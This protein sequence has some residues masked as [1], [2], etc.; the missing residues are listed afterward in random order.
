MFVLIVVR[1][2][3]VPVARHRDGAG[4]RHV[5]PLSADQEHEEHAE[6]SRKVRRKKVLKVC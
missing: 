4:H 5:V 6:S 3:G 1:F 2:Q